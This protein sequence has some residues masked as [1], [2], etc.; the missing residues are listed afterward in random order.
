ML[1]DRPEA[2]VAIAAQQLG[3][4]EPD[5]IAYAAVFLASD[6]SR[7]ITGHILPVDAGSFSD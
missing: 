5:D 3:L 4:I 7:M 1:A 2:K 6:E